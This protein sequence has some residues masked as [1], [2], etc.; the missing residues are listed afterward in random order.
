MGVDNDAGVVEAAAGIDGD[1]VE[2][3][4]DRVGVEIFV[5]EDAFKADSFVAFG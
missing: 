2:K 1:D 4:A 3:L 5:P